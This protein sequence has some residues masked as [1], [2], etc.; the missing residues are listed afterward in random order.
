MGSGTAALE[1]GFWGTGVS[2]LEAGINP[3]GGARVAGLGGGTK[4]TREAGLDVVG[5]PAGGWTS[6]ETGAG[7]CGAWR[8][9]SDAPSSSCSG[10]RRGRASLVLPLTI[11]PVSP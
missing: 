10:R 8:P 4:P 9:V 1:A 3:G 2:F 5:I 6:C 7:R 11:R